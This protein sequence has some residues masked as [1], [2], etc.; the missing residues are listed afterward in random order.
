VRTTVTVRS[1]PSSTAARWTRQSA[2]TSVRIRST[3]IPPRRTS[4]RPGL[5]PRTQ[6]SS[7]LRSGQVVNLAP[8]LRS[9]RGYGGSAWRLG[10]SAPRRDTVKLG[11]TARLVGTGQ[12]IWPPGESVAVPPVCGRTR[13]RDRSDRVPRARVQFGVQSEENSGAPSTNRPNESRAWT[14][15]ATPSVWLWSRRSGVRVPSLTPHKVSANGWFGGPVET[16]SRWSF[17]DAS[18][19]CCSTWRANPRGS[20]PRQIRQVR[21]RKGISVAELAARTDVDAQKITALEAGRFDPPFDVMIAVADG[22]GVRLSTL[23]PDD[24]EELELA[25]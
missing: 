10:G 4:S 13:E 6:L 2:S 9:M 14:A 16:S 1:L 21:E 20:R 25:A 18:T 7:S 5:K 11:V 23:I 22:I 3:R 15:T 12:S 8:P 24:R 19:R 17:A